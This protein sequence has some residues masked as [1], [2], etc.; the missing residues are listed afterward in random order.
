MNLQEL[1]KTAKE[2]YE[3]ST[4]WGFFIFLFPSPYFNRLQSFL[5][6]CISSVVS[7]QVRFKSM[8]DFSAVE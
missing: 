5:H 6:P 2:T 7:F 8:F 1:R 4:V 3:E